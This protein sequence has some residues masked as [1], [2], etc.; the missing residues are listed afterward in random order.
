MQL[1][2]Y[3]RKPQPS[4][5]EIRKLAIAKDS[6]FTYKSGADVLAT[7]KKFGWTPPSEYRRDFLF[8]EHR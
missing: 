1:L 5:P 7:W 3:L 2:K 8:G 6:H 4:K